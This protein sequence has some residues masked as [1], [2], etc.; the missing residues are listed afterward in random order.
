MIKFFKKIIKVK[1]RFKKPSKAD[2]LV[3]DIYSL[4]NAKILFEKY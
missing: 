2:V 4:P 1:I 3:Y